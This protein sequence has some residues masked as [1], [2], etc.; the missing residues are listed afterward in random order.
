MFDFTAE[1]TNLDGLVID[2][3]E[4]M[5]PVRPWLPESRARILCPFVTESTPFRSMSCSHQDG[6]TRWIPEDDLE[7]EP[8]ELAASC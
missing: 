6:L 8:G 2:E 4:W 5:I 3:K 1:C 7:C